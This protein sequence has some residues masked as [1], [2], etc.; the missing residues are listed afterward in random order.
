MNLIERLVAEKAALQQRLAM[1]NA[2]LDETRKLEE[3]A[4]EVLGE[5]PSVG[6]KEADK[7]LDHPFIRLATRAK[8][9]SVEQFEEAVYK[10]LEKSNKPLSR[11]EILEHV[12]AQGVRVGEPSHSA[13]DK[14]N[15]V[16]ARMSRMERVKSQR[17][18]G[19]WLEGSPHD[20]GS[21]ET[22]LDNI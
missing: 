8:S 7:A 13:L 2:L 10:L 4:R 22:L 15:I 17:G 16:S 9:T 1:I 11:K 5:V 21:S 3:K 20:A 6:H 14:A 12:E 18:L 19:Y